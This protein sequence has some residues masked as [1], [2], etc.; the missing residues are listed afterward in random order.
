VNVGSLLSQARRALSS[1]AEGRL[2][3][4]V[5]LS[6]VLGVSRAWIY[7]NADKA[8]EDQHIEQF[9]SCVERRASG[10]PMAYITG[11][12]EFWSLSL[13][14]TNDVLVPRPET[15][16]LVETA[17]EHI[18]P[19]AGWRVADL[20]TGSG[21]VALA[22][23]YERPH[24]EV[25]ATDI[26]ASAL[27]VARENALRLNLPRIHFHQG[28][29]FEALPGRF[30]VIVSNPPYIANADPHLLMGDCRFEPEAALSPGKDG[31]SAIHAIA[32]GARVALE[33]HGFLIFEHGYDQ[34]QQSRTLLKQ[35]GYL[36][37]QTVRDLAGLERVTVGRQS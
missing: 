30:H 14:I 12:R 37:V 10:E 5:L 6:H 34:G 31:M 35:L 11:S 8:V 27:R 23:A 24:C 22:L 3:A 29:W 4:E 36:E 13:K 1:Q 28:S 32:T 2:E 25:Y 9:F 26:S 19:G 33:N 15:E 17:L 16:L 21:A 7:A 18:P 20:G